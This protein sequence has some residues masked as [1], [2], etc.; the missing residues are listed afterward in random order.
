MLV[1]HSWMLRKMEFIKDFCWVT[2]ICGRDIWMLCSVK[3][4]DGLGVSLHDLFLTS[5]CVK[6]PWLC[7]LPCGLKQ[8]RLDF[9][10]SASTHFP[11]LDLSLWWAGV[12]FTLNLL[13]TLFLVGRASTSIR[14]HGP[15]PA[16]PA[17]FC[18]LEQMAFVCDPFHT[19]ED[20]E[21]QGGMRSVAG[22]QG[23]LAEDEWEVGR[24]KGGGR[25]LSWRSTRLRTGCVEQAAAAAAQT[26][27]TLA[28]T[29]ADQ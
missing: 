13:L 26:E 14:S 9:F 10:F 17:I 25:G 2:D 27:R 24:C 15:K 18:L 1:T 6:A 7:N 21:G 23:G 16:S 28:A 4:H 5:C 3:K 22:R 12:C 8:C 11:S 29:S 20:G 19:F